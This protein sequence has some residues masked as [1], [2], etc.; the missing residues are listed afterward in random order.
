MKEKKDKKSNKL[1]KNA[2][3]EGNH[4]QNPAWPLNKKLIADSNRIN[5]KP[6]LN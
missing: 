4:Q 1:R 3:G 6:A 2:E 5:V